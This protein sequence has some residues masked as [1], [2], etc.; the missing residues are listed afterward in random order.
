M[1][2]DNSVARIFD[3]IKDK[4]FFSCFSGEMATVI[5]EIP[6]SRERGKVYFDGMTLVDGKEDVED[7]IQKVYGYTKNGSKVNMEDYY[8]ES[9][10]Y[11]EDN[12]S[13]IEA[14]DELMNHEE[15]DQYLART[16]APFEDRID[17]FFEKQNTGKDHYDWEEGLIESYTIN[18]DGKVDVV[19]DVFVDASDLVDGHLPFKFGKIE[20]RFEA[21]DCGLTSLWGC[22]DEVTDYFSV[23]FNNLTTL[24]GCPHKVGSFFCSDNKLTSLDGCPEEVGDVFDIKANQL[25]SLEGCPAVIPGDFECDENLL[26]GNGLVGGPQEVEGDY[27]CNDCGLNSLE[28]APRKVGG[29]FE[30]YGNNL[31]N[32]VGAPVEVGGNFNCS[33]MDLKSFEGAPEII[34]GKL[35][36][37]H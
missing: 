20:G 28:G 18:E 14:L 24:E 27:H 10:A 9:G 12:T 35:I 26:E 30:C 7:D 6:E 29:N 1:E 4:V 19:G 2:N 15:Y 31:D 8:S 33:F 37:E 16:N 3:V 25:T 11:D 13:F 21:E 32:L 36:N 23:S 17:T 22:P 34:G 5:E